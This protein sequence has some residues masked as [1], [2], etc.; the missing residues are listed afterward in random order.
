MA[1]IPKNDSKNPLE[2][3]EDKKA[4]Q[5]AAAEDVLLREVDEAVRQD[6][7]SSF[8]TRYGKLLIALFV[9]GLAGFGGY[10]FWDGRQESAMERNSEALVAALD[11]IEAGNLATGSAALEPL[12]ANG[13]PGAQTA[14][15]MLTAGI[16]L[17]QGKPGEARAAFAAIAADENAPAAMRDIA[18]IREIA[19]A[20]DTMKPAEVIE[21]LKPLAVPGKPFFG[22]AGELVAMAYLDQGRQNE[23]GALFASIAK[24]KTV[25][26]GLRSRSRQMAGLYGV[27]AIEDVDK[28]LE[29]IGGTQA[30]PVTGAQ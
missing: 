23:A 30:A 20:Y 11:Q 28:V 21:R 5:E 2:T 12:I 19:A 15:R 18:T 3:P 9:L 16:A 25:P 7:L 4:R 27:D 22:S 1:L 26:E 29:G 17:E 13:N 24:D 10:L 8:V 6:Q 14:A